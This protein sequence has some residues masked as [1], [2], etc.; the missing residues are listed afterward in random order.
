MTNTVVTCTSSCNWRSHVRNSL[1]T[2]ASSAERLVQQQDGRL[3]RECT[4]EGH[5]LALPA[6]ELCRVALRE[7]LEV[8]QLQQFPDPAL[9]LDLRALADLKPEGD[10]A[11]HSEVLERRVVLEYEAD[12]APLGRQPGGVLSGDL[13]GAGVG[14]LEAGD[15]A[16]QRRLAAAAWSE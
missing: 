6:G 8:H 10:V 1:R 9:D 2:W 7:L 12:V 16:Q 14:S 4:R 15:D 11:I 3:D 5:P 13:D